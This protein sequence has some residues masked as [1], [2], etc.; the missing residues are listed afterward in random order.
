MTSTLTTA[1]GPAAPASISGYVPELDGL[2]AV[3]IL[4]VLVAHLIH[5]GAITLGRNWWYPYGNIGV[6]TFFVISGFLI[7]SLLLKEERRNAGRIDLRRFYI[8]RALR[9]FPALYAYL[10]VVFLLMRGGYVEWTPP[11][12]YLAVLFYVRNYVGRGDETNQ[13]WSLSI[14]EQFY[15]F[16]PF[17]LI[18]T[19]P[20]RRLAVTCGLIVL[21]CL[22]RTFLV[23]THRITEHALYMHTDVRIDTIL[24]GCLLSLAGSS[25]ALRP[26][27]ER[28]ARPLTAAVAFA[29]LVAWNWGIQPKPYFTYAFD[30]TLTAA[31]IAIILGFVMSNPGSAAVGVLRLRPLVYVGRLSYSIYLWQQLF[32]LG[33]EALGP[34]RGFPLNL[35]ATLAAAMVSYH[36]LESPIL[37]IKDR[38]FRSPTGAR[39]AALRNVEVGGA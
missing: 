36:C 20:R 17:L 22:W 11:H 38:Y 7:T 16:W 34:V 23:A 21:V 18:L 24:F 28:L 5:S 37:A 29:V 9:L 26:A 19:P 27:L 3:S 30:T 6:S 12:T 32:L 31:L 39:E 15:L 10:L 13:A 33:D 35:A 1:P 14:E 8:R 4:L 2:R 25:P